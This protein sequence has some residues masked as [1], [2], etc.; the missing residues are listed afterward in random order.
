MS[1]QKDFEKNETKFLGKLVNFA[2]KRVLE[3]GCGEGRLTWTYAR[4][5]RQVVGIDPDPDAVRVAHYDMPT[6]L[7]KTTAFACASSLNLPFPRERFDIAL[8]S[9]SL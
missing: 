8:L 1:F 3:V 9:W 6:D 4:S 7:R 5:A 2:G